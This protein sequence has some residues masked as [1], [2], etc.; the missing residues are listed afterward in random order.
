M[1]SRA[2]RP[3]MLFAALKGARVDGHD[4][5]PQALAAGAAGIVDGLDELQALAAAYRRRLAAKVI[6]V[7][8]SAGKTTTK[9]L[10]RAFLSQCGLTCATAGNFNNHIGLPL[11]ILN[12]ARDARFLVL[13]MG[14]NHPGEIRALCDIARPDAGL[15]TGIGTAHLEFFGTREGIAREKGTLL[16]SLPETGFAVASAADPCLD[17]LR[18]LS[19]APFEAVEPRQDWMRAALPP[20]LPGEHNVSNAC[21][22]FAMAEHFGFERERVKAA[23]A[24]FELPGARWRT[25]VRDGVTYV[26]DTYN[27][28][29]DSM[30][31]ALNA[32]AALPG[33]G[34]R[35]AVLGDMFELGARAEELHRAVFEHAGRLGLDLVIAVG[36]I[37]SRCPAALACRNAEELKGLLAAEIRPGDRVFLKASHGMELGSALVHFS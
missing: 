13:E 35:V 25:F 33:E 16:A 10:L 2:V 21:L 26:D 11:M 9:E 31:A 27:A 20:S 3:G 5:I 12:C 22:A 1:D 14:T 7:T 24:A 18:G 29:P 34:R 30:I 32:F 17:I 19:R 23:L 4:F 15:V 37:S 6:G 36:E 28:N 8:G